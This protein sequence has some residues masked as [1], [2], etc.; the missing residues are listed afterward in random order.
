MLKELTAARKNQTR[1]TSDRDRI[2]PRTRAWLLAIIAAAS[3]LVYWLLVSV[4]LNPKLSL[5]Y[6]VKGARYGGPITWPARWLHLASITPLTRTWLFTFM[7]AGVVLLW[8]AAIYL[9]R[10]DNRKALTAII[11]VG[12]GLF[13]AMFLFTPLFQ[14]KDIFSYIFHGRAMSVYHSNPY[15]LIP[16][17]RPHDVVYPLVGWK[18]NASVYGPV[19]NYFSW[20]ITKVAGN[21]IVSNIFGF[22][23]VAFLGYAACLPM[24]YW[25][26]RRISPGKENMALAISAWC[27]ILVMHVLGGGHN[28]AL[29]AAFV[30]G[31]FLLYRKG[32][33]LTGIAVVTCGAMIKIVGVLALV[34][35]L[36]L[37]VRDKRGAP[38]KRL[39]AGGATAIGVV[40]L[41]YLPFLQSLKIFN[42]TS[43]MTKLYSASAIPRLFS[44]FYEGV[45]TRGGMSLVHATTVAE[46][47]VHLVFLG[48][49]VVIGI[50][51]LLRVKDYYSMVLCAAALSL[52]FCFTSTYILPWYL[53]LGLLLA[54]MTG[55]NITT[56]VLVGSAAVFSLFRIPGPA[57]ESPNLYTA[58][59]FL[60]LFIGW[61]LLN[62]AVELRKARSGKA[63]AVP[64]LEPLERTIVED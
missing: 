16:H 12:F 30:I 51:L 18:F 36:V 22:K 61:I 2:S 26:T 27:P 40:V 33:L 60:L 8:L 7:I 24:I 32:Y 42:S 47:R 52:V 10:R 3:G 9:V 58:L 38:L 45:L 59:P 25:L 5:I 50:L 57:S 34:P 4:A 48:I 1:M 20:I 19:F 29:M 62:A 44:A 43:H 23:F 35:M 46:G 28:D 31:G 11:L 39:V 17:A 54:S 63:T 41:L 21:N 37:Y 6:D 49:A 14:S 15:L 56:G 64:V 53:V 55:W 13:A